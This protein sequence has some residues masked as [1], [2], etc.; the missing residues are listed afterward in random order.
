MLVVSRTIFHSVKTRCR[1][2]WMDNIL[3]NRRTTIQHSYIS[4]PA[5]SIK[6]VN[7]ARLEKVFLFRMTTNQ[8]I[9]FFF[10]IS[11]VA[12]NRLKFISDALIEN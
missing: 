6:N 10:S 12:F 11:T 5:K 9:Q 7:E 4:G 8:L 2:G 1:H 3:N